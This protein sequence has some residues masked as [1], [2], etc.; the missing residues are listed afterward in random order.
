MTAIVK[1]S[2]RQSS[3]RSSIT[4]VTEVDNCATAVDSPPRK[5]ESGQRANPCEQER[6]NEQKPHETPARRPR[7]RRRLNSCRRAVVRARSRLAMFPQAIRKHEPDDAKRHEEGLLVSLTQSRC[8]QG[9]R[10]KR[11]WKRKL[12]SRRHRVGREVRGLADLAP[13]SAADW[14]P[15]LPTVRASAG[16]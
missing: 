4:R 13:P 3:E 9:R 2:T 16:P 10:N 1:A 14:L 12:A 7:A 6:F 8:A 5:H 11:E 15:P